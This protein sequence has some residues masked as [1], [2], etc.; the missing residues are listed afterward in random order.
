MVL[1]ILAV[2]CFWWKT[3]GVSFLQFPSTVCLLTSGN[4]WPSVKPRPR[5]TRL[6]LHNIQLHEAKKD[7]R[8]QLSKTTSTAA[9]STSA[10]TATSAAASEVSDEGSSVDG[11]PA[12]SGNED[13]SHTA[14]E[15]VKESVA[16]GVKESV[17]EDRDSRRWAVQ[18]EVHQLCTLQASL[19]QFLAQNKIFLE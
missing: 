10:T 16:E 13:S 12:G 6:H 9:A 17:A 15:G 18:T 3:C 7:Y 8:S 11:P 4:P 5:D 1:F 14:H 19:S 2:S